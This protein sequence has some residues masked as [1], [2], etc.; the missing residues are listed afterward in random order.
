MAQTQH[1]PGA[2]II[3]IA[4]H[5][6]NVEFLLAALILFLARP[7]RRSGRTVPFQSLRQQRQK[8]LRSQDG[9]GSWSTQFSRPWKQ[10]YHVYVKAYV[11]EV[12]QEW[13]EGIVYNVVE[14]V[15]GKYNIIVHVKDDEGNWFI[16]RTIHSNNQDPIPSVNAAD[17]NYKLSNYITGR[18]ERLEGLSDVGSK[19]WRCLKSLSKRISVSKEFPEQ[20]VVG[21]SLLGDDPDSPTSMR[22]LLHS[23]VVDGDVENVVKISTGEESCTAQHALAYLLGQLCGI[24]LSESARSNDI[25][26]KGVL[27]QLGSN[28]KVDCPISQVF[29]T[30]VMFL[31]TKKQKSSIQ[32]RL[33]LIPDTRPCSPIQTS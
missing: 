23:L 16:P 9:K 27:D 31:R 19:H 18:D 11:N 26:P 29:L 15:D 21:E 25:D 7:H 5:A 32:L 30:S 6:I 24:E 20:D 13:M 2:R 10:G 1:L 3:I 22:N 28:I 33:F 8:T 17:P 12:D 14:D 4:R